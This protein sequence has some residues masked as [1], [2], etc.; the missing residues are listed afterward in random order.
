MPDLPRDRDDVSGELRRRLGGGL[1][2]PLPRGEC[3]AP[4]RSHLGEFHL[5][6]APDYELGERTRVRPM[7]PIERGHA[8]VLQQHV[9]PLTREA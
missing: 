6:D 5:S 9:V 7:P 4:V 3:A 8:R 2:L 1:L